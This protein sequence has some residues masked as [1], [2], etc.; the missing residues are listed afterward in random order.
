MTLAR[1]VD[2]ADPEA[3]RRR[4]RALQKKVREIEKLKAAPPETLEL[5]QKDLIAVLQDVTEC[6]PSKKL[7]NRYISSQIYTEYIYISHTST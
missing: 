6:I 1:Q 3:V 2:L 4:L 7:T 5:L